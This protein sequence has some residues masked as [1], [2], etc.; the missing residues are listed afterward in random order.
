MTSPSIP[1]LDTSG[2]EEYHLWQHGL[3]CPAKAT[4]HGQHPSFCEK[5][6]PHV[7]SYARVWSSLGSASW[8]GIGGS[9]LQSR[10]GE[11]RQ[12]VDCQREE[13]SGSTQGQRMCGPPHET[14]GTERNS[15]PHLPRSPSENLNLAKV[16]P[17]LSGNESQ[18][19]VF[20]ITKVQHLY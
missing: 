9:F 19:Q 14:D 3:H 20:Q 17:S 5:Y 13:A 6:V 10:V 2:I 8:I 12:T 11:Q 16:M 18:I 4:F 1:H 7:R 15:C